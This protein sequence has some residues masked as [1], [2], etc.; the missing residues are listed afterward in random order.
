MS[1]NINPISGGP[2][3]TQIPGYEE[4]ADI[5]AALRLYHYGTTETVETI[6][7]VATNSVAKH[8][9]NLRDDVTDLQVTGVGSAYVSTEPTGAVDGFIWMDSDDTLG[10]MPGL[11]AAYQTTAPSTPVTGALWVDSTNTNA[12][13]LKVYDGSTWKVI[14]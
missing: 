14:V 1:E 4:A 13:S 11:V 12:L 9:Q 8:L 6:A 10:A 7:D 2:Y 5:Q 3:Q